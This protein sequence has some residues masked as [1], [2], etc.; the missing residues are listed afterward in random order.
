LGGYQGFKGRCA[1]YICYKPGGLNVYYTRKST[2][3]QVFFIK[4]SN[5]KLD[6]PLYYGY[7]RVYTV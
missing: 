5:K 1:V 7:T 6:K 3:C 2:T 4:I